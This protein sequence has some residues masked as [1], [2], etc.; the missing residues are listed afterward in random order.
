MAIDILHFD[1][2]PVTGCS[3]LQEQRLIMSPKLFGQYVNP[4]V[5]SGIGDVVYLSDAQLSPKDE[6]GMHSHKE[7][8]LVSIM[9][10]GIILH[11]GS[12]AEGCELSSGN[13]LIQRAGDEGFSHSETNLSESS[14]RMIQIWVLPTQKDSLSSYKL[15]KLATNKVSRVYGGNSEQTDVF[16]GNTI[17]DVVYLRALEK[18]RFDRPFLAYLPKGKGNAENTELDQG[19]LLKGEEL[20]FQASTEAILIVMYEG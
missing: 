17:I 5:W 20:H 7:I 9:V 19:S 2:L 16:S 10:D 11:Q 12:L 4:G 1:E 8:D 14:H 6:I 3:G 18:F 15:L 13:V